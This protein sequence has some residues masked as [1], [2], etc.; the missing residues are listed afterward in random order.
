MNLR[1]FRHFL[2]DAEVSVVVKAAIFGYHVL[3]IGLLA[4]PQETTSPVSLP[5]SLAQPTAGEA[6]EGKA[7]VGA[8]T[9]K[10]KS[11]GGDF[12]KRQ[13]EAHP[14]SQGGYKILQDAV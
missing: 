12:F 5:Q 2:M 4:E 3:S 10:H 1:T 14:I 11:G 9:G 7:E 13:L 6:R 8:D